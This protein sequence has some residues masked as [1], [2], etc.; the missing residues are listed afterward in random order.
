MPENALQAVHV[1]FIL[2]AAEMGPLLGELSKQIAPEVPASLLPNPK[3]TKEEIRMSMQSE[4]PIEEL[5]ECGTLTPFTGPEC[6]GVLASLKEGNRIRFR[7][8]TGHAFSADSLLAS[9]SE[10]IEESLWSSARTIQESMMLLN[11]MGDHF[12]EVNLPK[13]AALYFKKAKEAK[14]R[15][16]ALRKILRNHEQLTTEF[17]N[18]QAEKGRDEE[19]K[20]AFLKKE[21]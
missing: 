12:A 6:H 10:N 7:C 18:Y 13:L 21:L 4:N 20:D 2:P 16:N 5:M 3:L 1:D 19:G 14:E 17:L 15:G 11:H 9:I 8:H